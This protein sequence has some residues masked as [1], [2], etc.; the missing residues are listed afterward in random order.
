M[1]QNSTKRMRRALEQNERVYYHRHDSQI[2]VWHGGPQVTI[3]DSET[4]EEVNVFNVKT[5]GRS[6]AEVENSVAINIARRGFDRCG[7]SQDDTRVVE[8]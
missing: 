4:W 7:R 8:A 3:Y 5:V 1:E 6:M 2:A